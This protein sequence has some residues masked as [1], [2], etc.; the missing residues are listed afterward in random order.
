MALLYTTFGPIVGLLALLAFRRDCKAP[1]D[2]FGRALHRS[3]FLLRNCKAKGYSVLHISLAPL[4]FGTATVP[5]DPILKILELL[6]IIELKKTCIS[7]FNGY[8][9]IEHIKKYYPFHV[10]WRSSELL[11]N[12]LIESLSCSCYTFFTVPFPPH[13][14]FLITNN[15]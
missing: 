14:H 8:V 15:L 3:P 13:I 7:L 6:Q 9:F 10:L 2:F 12:L 4:P 5:F 11:G 1:S